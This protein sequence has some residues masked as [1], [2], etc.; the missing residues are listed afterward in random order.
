M[1]H[2]LS[3]GI[4]DIYAAAERLAG[5]AV[6]TP[7]L[8]S[9]DL[10]D[11]I[12]GRVLFKAEVLQRTGSFKFR[13]AYNKIASLSGEERARG[14]VAF[15]SGNH[16][17]GVAAS[18]KMFGIKAV[19]AM[20]SDAPAIKIGNV[21]RMGAEV[22]LF[23]RERE[24]RA[25]VVAPWLEKGLVMVPPFDDPAIIAGQGTIGLEI[26]AQA[27]ELGAGLD[28]VV[29]P[30]GGG[31]LI[32]GISIAMKTGSPQAAVWAVEPEDFDDTRRSL[33]SGERVGN[34]PGRN[35]ICDAILT[36]P[37]GEITFAI[38]RANLAGVAT[39]SDKMVAQ[40]MRDAM[41]FLK[42][43]VEPGGAVGL[44]ALLSG[45]ID[46]KGKC[47]AVVLSGGNVDFSTYARIM[48]E[49]ESSG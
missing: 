46:A 10:N 48:A 5:L 31:G 9:P 19:I 13:G 18:A 2:P 3:P 43:V 12:G 45:A 24:E 29:A 38:N 23:D 39:V 42:L 1:S 11:K 32:G 37:P 35:S 44:A 17:Q 16:A 36:S 28:A 25:D 8:E 4:A 34:P 22:V 41:S 30:C 26:L 49:G 20:P 40:A 27:Q 7:L 14:V 15:S 6:K 33:E 47:V 21:R